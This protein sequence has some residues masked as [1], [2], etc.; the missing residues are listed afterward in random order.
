MD[1]P[2]LPKEAVRI[3]RALS[4]ASLLGFSA[5]FVLYGAMLGGCSS[6]VPTPK[7]HQYSFPSGEA[8]VD[9]PKRPFKVLGEVK[10]K[11]TYSSI[12]F[13][14]GDDVLCRN[15]YNKA[16][17]DLVKR[18]KDVGADAIANIRSV[19]FYEDG[20]HQIFKTPECTDDGEEG[21]VLV[22]ATAIK[23]P[24]PPPPKP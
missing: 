21:E 14:H 9:A 12:D 22:A 7:M 2:Q 8:F 5:F 11:A 3:Q 6:T 19:V 13:E 16:V 24:P 20:T 10:S 15:Y 1:F 4:G 23:W 17:K 18:A